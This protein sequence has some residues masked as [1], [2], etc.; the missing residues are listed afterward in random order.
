MIFCLKIQKKLHHLNKM[1]L[2][3]KQPHIILIKKI[4]NLSF[5]F[6]SGF[7]FRIFGKPPFPH[8]FAL[9]EHLANA[10]KGGKGNYSEK[11]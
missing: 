11:G 1:R 5:S 9:F 10:P 6:I 2:Q 3:F 8:P 7:S 4:H